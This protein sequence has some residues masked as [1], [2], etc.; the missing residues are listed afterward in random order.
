MDV[1]G[2]FPT[3]NRNCLTK[4]MRGM[5]ID[6]NLVMWVKIFM[7]DRTAR[8]E[9]NGSLGHEIPVETGLPQGSPVSP[10][11]FNIYMA[12]LAKSVEQ[13]FGEA[14]SLSFVDDITWIVRG[15]GINEVTSNLE[16][17]A[18]LSIKWAKKNAVQFEIEKSDAIF[19]SRKKKH[20]G[21]IKRTIRIDD[22]TIKYNQKELRWLGVYLDS[23]LSLRNHHKRWCTKAKQQQARISRLCKQTGL[24][25]FSVANL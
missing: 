25:G 20:L 1:K 6:E 9:V 19:F 12:D 10:I 24:P 8:I 21:E 23:Q 3:V 17:C 11:L 5:D 2:A 18:D 14:Y 4:K 7:S 22:Y 15:D 16:K 13:E